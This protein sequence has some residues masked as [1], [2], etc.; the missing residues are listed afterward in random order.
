M[1]VVC[2]NCGLV[3]EKENNLKEK[4]CI[5]CKRPFNIVAKVIDNQAIHVTKRKKNHV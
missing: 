3:Q 1:I 5:K 4:L 2:P